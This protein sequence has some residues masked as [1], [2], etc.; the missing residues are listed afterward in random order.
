M[1]RPQ[2]SIRT[3]LWL[4]LAA[5]FFFGGV[6][7]EQARRRREDQIIYEDAKRRSG[8]L[9]PALPQRLREAALR[10]AEIR[11]ANPYA[12]EDGRAADFRPAPQE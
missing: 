10:N 11:N 2:F 1:R 3:L 7:F 12:G 4:M 6:Y 8:R 9:T 5:S